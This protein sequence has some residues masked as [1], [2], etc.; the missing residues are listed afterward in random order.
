MY[1]LKT[2]G[3]DE[4]LFGTIRQEGKETSE[5]LKTIFLKHKKCNFP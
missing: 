1:I 3:N 5:V 4:Y 2:V